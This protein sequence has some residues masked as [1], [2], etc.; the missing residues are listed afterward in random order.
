MKIIQKNVS[1]FLQVVPLNREE[2]SSSTI[3][4][5]NDCD[6]IAAKNYYGY[7][8][9]APDSGNANK[10]YGYKGEPTN[11]KR[12]R[13]SSLKSSSTNWTHRRRASLGSCT[14]DQ[15]TNDGSSLHR[16]RRSITFHDN[17]EVCEVQSLMEQ[18][19]KP[20][21][22]WFQQ[23][24]FNRIKKKIHLIVAEVQKTNGRNERGLC[25]R[26]I[27]VYIDAQHKIAKMERRHSLYDSVYEE[28]LYRDEYG[29]SACAD[30]G[31]SH[32]SRIISKQAVREAQQ[33]ALIDQESIRSYVKET[34]RYMRRC[35]M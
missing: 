21:E 10:Y 32:A 18:G 28:Q 11:M 30:E 31:I 5:K 34:R 17:D 4:T 23:R 35:S 22:L 9:A 20:E 16:R 1:N 15:H 14:C 24:D 25:T 33:Q 27:E 2:S 12:E 7:E 8:E 29:S 3:D 19:G 13:R 26:G 6:S